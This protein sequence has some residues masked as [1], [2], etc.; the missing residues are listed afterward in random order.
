LKLTQFLPLLLLST[1]LVH[2][3]I[4]TFDFNPALPNYGDIPDTYGDNITAV[5]MGSFGYGM[6]NG[7][8]PNITTDYAMR[9][10]TTDALV[11]S[12]L[13]SW[14]VNYGD[15]TNIAFVP[16]NGG[17]YGQI[18]LTAG[19]GMQVRL[20]SFDLG[21]YSQSN[22]LNS[23]V[24][25]R[26]DGLLVTD[27]LGTILGAGGTHSTF[28]PA[29]TGTTIQIEYGH[30]DWN[31]GIDNINFDEVAPTTSSVPEPT[32]LALGSLGLAALAVVHRRKR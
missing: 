17:N 1:T 29:L 16:V 30:N 4:L 18:T 25:I 14:N 20:N 11:L 24:R 12:N 15:L 7:F 23:I 27:F 10:T 8:T 9:S 26:V 21:G 13:D 3:S 32:S 5:N 22:H 2:A 28:T 31:V 6:G 19:A